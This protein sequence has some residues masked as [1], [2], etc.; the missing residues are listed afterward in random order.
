MLSA[1]TPLD[2]AFFSLLSGSYERLLGV[3]LAP[4]MPSGTGAVDW[5]YH[6]AP[7]AVLAQDAGDDPVFVY[8]NIAA[9]RRF[10]YSWH[11][12]SGLPS[13]LSTPVTDRAKRDRAMAS[14]LSDGYVEGYRGLRE[15]GRGHR[16]WIEDVTI[17]NVS[18]LDGVVRGQAAIIR[19]W[20]D[21]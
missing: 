20:S 2:L 16:F 21:A 11:E 9:Q 6:D 7:F 10:A 3:P 15:S 4:E 8:A 18:D 17:W 19:S 1:S 14:V 5:I 12:F 13:R